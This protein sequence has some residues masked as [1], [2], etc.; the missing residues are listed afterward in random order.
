MKK[1]TFFITSMSSGGAEHQ[2]A[3]LTKLLVKEMYEVTI[4]TFADVSDHYILDSKVKRVTLAK[5]KNSFIKLLTIFKFF[6]FLKTDCIISFGQR[7]NLLVLI[8]LIFRPSVKV[9]AGERNFTYGKQD[10]IE[11]ILFYFSSQS[12]A[13]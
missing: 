10:K 4:V 13:H 2:M 9:I 7:E 5:G 12:L 11:R 1:V 3:E 6:L 8:P